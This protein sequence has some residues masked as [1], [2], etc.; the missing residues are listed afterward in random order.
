MSRMR[1]QATTIARDYVLARLKPRTKRLIR[2]AICDVHGREGWG[3]MERYPGFQAAT[4]RIREVL[5]AC[6]PIYVDLDSE[7][8]FRLKGEPRGYRPWLF[9]FEDGDLRVV[10]L[11][12]LAPYV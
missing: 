2:Q 8:A 12:S 4:N 5:D 3:G 10:V 6:G 9:K 1:E 7:E 11:G